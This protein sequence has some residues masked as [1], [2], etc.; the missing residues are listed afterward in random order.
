M[1]IRLRSLSTP[2]YI[3]DFIGIYK[4]INPLRN[5]FNH[6]GFKNNAMKY[7][8]MKDAIT[9]ILNDIFSVIEKHAEKN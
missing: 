2:E 5:D 6:A 7:D 3:R 1:E 9:P 8:K 4:K